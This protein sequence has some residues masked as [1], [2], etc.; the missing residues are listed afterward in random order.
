MDP[1]QRPAGMT[2]KVRHPRHP[3]SGVHLPP[4]LPMFSVGSPSAPFPNKAPPPTRKDER[5]RSI[6]SESQH[7]KPIVS[8]SIKD[9]AFKIEKVGTSS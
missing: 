5:G 1:R 4:S 2:Q 6:L 8:T 7:R 9:L 3:L